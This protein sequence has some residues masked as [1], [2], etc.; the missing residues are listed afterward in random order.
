ME[1]QSNIERH[2]AT[3]TN[4]VQTTNKQW[5][6]ME[7]QQFNKLHKLLLDM[8]IIFASTICML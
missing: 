6:R 5:R 7:A 3:Q 4:I 2:E 8:H 1:Q